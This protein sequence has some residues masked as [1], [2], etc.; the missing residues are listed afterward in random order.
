[1][2]AE[3]EMQ[4]GQYGQARDRLE[5]ALSRPGMEGSPTLLAPLARAKILLGQEDEA[6]H[7][8]DRAEAQ[9]RAEGDL[10]DLIQVQMAQAM[11]AARLGAW[12]RARQ[13]LEESLAATTNQP[14]VR[15]LILLEWGQLH[16][17][18]GEREQAADRLR[19]AI[20][21]FQR[22]G[23]RPYIE[24]ARAYLA[25]IARDETGS[26]AVGSADIGS[27]RGD[28]DGDGSDDVRSET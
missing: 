24:Q 3:R 22:I 7:M 17:E 19:E 26:R 6:K 1:M 9:S 27:D 18:R 21:T 4:E 11:L 28:S 10:M 16:R 15:G 8:L 5:G 25:E 13:L 2:M 12:D 20:G 23:A 14:W